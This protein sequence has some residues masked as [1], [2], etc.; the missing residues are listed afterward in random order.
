VMSL[1][2]PKR[3]AGNGSNDDRKVEL[4]HQLRLSTSLRRQ[5][6]HLPR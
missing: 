1:L 4:R 2:D 6:F 3:T 5:G